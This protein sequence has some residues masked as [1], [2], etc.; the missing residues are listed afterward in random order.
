M[1]E[2]AARHDEL[3]LELCHERSQRRLDCF[4]ARVVAAHVEVGDVEQAPGHARSVVAAPRA[5]STL[6]KCTSLRS[7]SPPSR[8]GWARRRRSPSSLRAQKAALLV[9]SS[10][11][12][13]PRRGRRAVA[14]LAGRRP[15]T[16][17]R[18]R[19][20]RPGG[21]PGARLPEP[22]ARAGRSELPVAPAR[23]SPPDGRP[24]ARCTASAS[25]STSRRCS[26][27]RRAARL[28]SL[29]ARLDRR[30]LRA[31]PCDDRGGRLREALP[32]SRLDRDLD[33]QRPAGARRR[34]REGAGRIPR[35]RRK[36][37]FRASW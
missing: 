23:R 27:R 21:W 35:R 10:P 30:R 16:A 14:L 20:R 7:S 5:A 9:V 15:R 26:T 18:A 37:G 34:A 2:V 11:P 6:S 31:R 29:P 28:A 36:P 13:P 25:T 12:A 32:R 33:G 8:P 22:A 24:A 1:R 17:G 19:L 3:R 4:A